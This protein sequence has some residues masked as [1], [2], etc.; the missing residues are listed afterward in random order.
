MQTRSSFLGGLELT[1][2]IH[3]STALKMRRLLYCYTDRATFTLKNVG[4]FF[5][6]Q[7]RV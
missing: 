2:L 1:A 4:Y 6:G 5:R 7:N 3:M